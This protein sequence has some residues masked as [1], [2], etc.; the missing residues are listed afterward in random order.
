MFGRSG[1]PLYVLYPRPSGGKPP[2]VLPQILTER[3]VLDA[4]D[5]A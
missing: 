4:L 3:I 1:V 2:V 5:G